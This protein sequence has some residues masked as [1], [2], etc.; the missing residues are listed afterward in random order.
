MSRSTPRDPN[1]S[2][3]CR[4]LL[5]RCSLFVPAL[6]FGAWTAAG[7]AE[8]GAGDGEMTP[9]LLAI[10]AILVAAKIGGE[11]MERLNQPAVLGEL[12]FGIVLGNIGLTGIEFFDALKTAPFLAV[13]AEI[14]VI[15]LLFQVGLESN[16]DELLAVGASAVGVAVLGVVAP[17]ALGYAVSSVFLPADTAWYVHLFLGAT[18]AATSVGITARVLKD[19]GVM[20]ARESRVILG[21]AV[22]DDVLGLIVLAIVLGLVHAADAG[23]ALEVS[24]APILVIV[25]KAVGFLAGAIILG[26]LVLLPL[27]RIVSMARSAS[28]PV[29]L[30]VA[31]C[32]LMAALAELVGLA[33]IVGAFAAGLVVDDAIARFFGKK[34]EQYRIGDSIAPV[35]TIFVPVF[36]VYMGLRVDLRAFFSFDV[37][38][39]AGVLSVTAIASKQ[40]CSLAVFEKGLNRW[41]VGMGMVP[42][43]EVGLIFAG[44]GATAMVAGTP[45]FSGETFAAIVA[46][47]MVTTLA[48]PPLLKAVFSGS[49]ASRNGLIPRP[50]V[51]TRSART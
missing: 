24:I 46:M 6:V 51:D 42:R 44:V 28:V 8:G 47:V 30:A 13:A 22:V 19:L 29:V 10:A 15:L 41:A 3:P 40:I 20:D 35:S 12:L 16:L 37:L 45:V 25:A 23:G 26:R 7:A 34:K 11:L 39:F 21:A 1:R 31:Y 27:M 32:F 18:L 48:T 14:G 38:L 9:F 43:G 5:G 2:R 4:G 33:D 36:F 17:I 49:P 50:S